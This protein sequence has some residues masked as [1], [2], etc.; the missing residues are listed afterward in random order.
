M[1]AN[2]RLVLLVENDPFWLVL[3]AGTI[4]SLDKNIELSCANTVE[5]AN[6]LLKLGFRYDLII[7]DHHLDSEA[8]G[9]SLWKSCKEAN[10][11]IPFLLVSGLKKPEFFES[12]KTEI[13]ETMSLPIY[14]EKPFDHKKLELMLN[15]QLGRPIGKKMIPENNQLSQNVDGEKE[16][17][18]KV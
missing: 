4:R 16:L 15:W 6:D 9:F 2:K 3:I 14:M 17:Y 1:E 12:I 13:T 5:E 7:A 8:T 11:R 18:T 10:R